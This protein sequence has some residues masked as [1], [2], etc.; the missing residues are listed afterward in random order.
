MHAL[1]AGVYA[2]SVLI[3]LLHDDC[4]VL[5]ADSLASEKGLGPLKFANKI[6]PIGYMNTVI[7]GTGLMDLVIDWYSFI[8]K[9]VVAKDLLCLNKITPKKLQ[10]L[11][12]SYNNHHDSTATIYQFGYCVDK[13]KHIGFAYRSS[14]GFESEELIPS[15]GIKPS[16]GI[17]ITKDIP[18]PEE[19]FK[20]YAIRMAIE[21]KARDDAK[22]VNEQLG[23]GGKLFSCILKENEIRMAEIYEFPD[24]NSQYNLMLRKLEERKSEMF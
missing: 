11:Y 24:K 15:I 10:E 12:Q 6:F 17:D 4:V 3:Y 7:T 19:N 22:N 21:Q 13:K 20:D 5:V 2:M 1:S 16:D 9:H 14:N 23:I 18:E 8:Q